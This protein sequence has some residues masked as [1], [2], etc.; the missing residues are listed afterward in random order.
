MSAI[1]NLVSDIVDYAGLFPPAKLP[2]DQ[3]AQNYEEYL[4]SNFN[5]MLAR[6]IIPASRLVELEQLSS[7]VDSGHHWRI[8][9]LVPSVDAAD[10]AFEV[11]MNS[12]DDFNARHEDTGRA[13]VDTI[14]IKAG[15][16]ELIEATIKKIPKHINAFLEVPHDQDPDP[17]IAAVAKG[18]SNIFAKIRTGGVT[19]DLIPPAEQVARFVARCVE[20]DVGFKATAGLHHPICGNYRLTYEPNPDFGDMFGFLNVFVAAAF[21]F[22][23]LDENGLVQILRETN[24]TAFKITDDAITWNDHSV[25]GKKIADI[26]KQKTISFGSCSFTEPTQELSQLGLINVEVA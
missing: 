23:G 8:S 3:V 20:H 25:S 18:D 11:A 26:R 21:A 14:E 24:V 10:Q 17:L 15:T 16:L 7:F 22:D 19:D 5:W 12:I 4:G 2:I 9:S 13:L 1:R 6:L